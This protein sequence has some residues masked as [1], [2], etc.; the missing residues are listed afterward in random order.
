MAKCAVCNSRKGKRKCN[1]ENGS[2]CSVC[3]G[4]M[5]AEEKCRECSFFSGSLPRRNYRHVPYFPVKVLSNNFE[6]QE[7]ANVIE[8]AI[9]QFDTK[10]NHII[11]D[12]TAL[13][14]VE[15]LLDKYHF[16]DKEMKVADRIEEEGLHFVDEAIRKD[17][18]GLSQEV[19]SK[20][21][22]TI[23]RS[24]TRHMNGNREY[25]E[26]IHKFVGI[27]VG[28]GIRAVPRFSQE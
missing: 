21:L 12:N 6:L 26:F 20:I 22:G 8:S 13:K 23:H 7:Y 15:L 9:C 25:I 19:L 18:E 24:V 1:A 2:I 27:R 11:D 14:I 28:K 3:C 5:R 16:N 10:V 17:L 4:E